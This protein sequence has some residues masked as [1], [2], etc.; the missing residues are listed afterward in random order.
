MTCNPPLEKHISYQVKWVEHRQPLG[1]L[2]GKHG[3]WHILEWGIGHG[4]IH[5]AAHFLGPWGESVLPSNS[6][7]LP[8]LYPSPCPPSVIIAVPQTPT[9]KPADSIECGC[10]SNT[11]C[12]CLMFWSFLNHSCW[13]VS[14]FC[15]FH[16]DDF[17]YKTARSEGMMDD[18]SNKNHPMLGEMTWRNHVFVTILRVAQNMPWNTTVTFRL[19]NMTSNAYVAYVMRHFEPRGSL[20]TCAYLSKTAKRWPLIPPESV[21]AKVQRRR[22]SFNTYSLGCLVLFQCYMG[23][24][25]N[26]LILY[27][28]ISRTTQSKQSKLKESSKLKLVLP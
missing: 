17:W 20:S 18:W 24:L 14:I 15:C 3:L 11:W 13:R 23:C 7:F 12:F 19:F 26:W 22:T 21:E 1:G 25:F 4:D 10:G 28:Y 8:H 2:P 16:L 27:N 9:A 5:Q 6:V